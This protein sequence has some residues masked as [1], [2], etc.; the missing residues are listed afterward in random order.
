M[1][2]AGRIKINNSEVI[3][4][5]RRRW[6]G[7]F[8]WL[9]MEE[10]DT[11]VLVQIR[12]VEE[13][14]RKI[15]VLHLDSKEFGALTLNLGSEG[16]SIKFKYPP[17]GVFQYGRDAFVFWRH[18]VRQYRRGICP[19]NSRMYNVTR[20]LVGNYS[21]WDLEE[22]KAAFD[23]KIYSLSEAIKLINTN[24]CRSVALPRNYA[25][26]ASITKEPDHILFHWNNPIARVNNEGKI[27][28]MIEHSYKY[29]L[30]NM[31]VDLE[32]V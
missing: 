21:H 7:T 10:K 30:E 27:T 19:D 4:D 1:V 29:V 28:L 6:E 2:N 12:Q 14:E 25:L 26:S 13:N 18:P 9:S 32:S 3:Q 20:N 8:V 24:K 5:F 17:V 23:H 16:H 22:V 31:N 15:G 11:E